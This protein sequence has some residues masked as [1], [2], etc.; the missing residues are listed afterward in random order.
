MDK[1]CEQL[2]SLYND[3]DILFYDFSLVMYASFPSIRQFIC[4]EWIILLDEINKL[5]NLS[6]FKLFVRLNN[7]SKETSKVKVG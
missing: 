1:Q 5:Y 6:Y 4:S 2:K 7:E 3:I